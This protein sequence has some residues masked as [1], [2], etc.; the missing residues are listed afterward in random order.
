MRANQDFLFPKVYRSNKVH[1]FFYPFTP[2]RKFTL[3]TKI[4]APK[5]HGNEKVKPRI[6]DLSQLL[7]IIIRCDNP[8]AKIAEK[9]NEYPMR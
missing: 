3:V 4:R 2:V 7:P 6:D 5:M 1:S 9:I 8:I